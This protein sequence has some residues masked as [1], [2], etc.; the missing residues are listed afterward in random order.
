SSSPA[1]AGSLRRN[2]SSIT[3]SS[4]AFI[5]ARYLRSSPS[6]RASWISSIRWCASR[7][8]HAIAA[9]HGELGNRLR[10]VTLTQARWPDEQRVLARL[11]E[12]Q[13]CK[14]EHAAFRKP[15]VIAPVEVLQVLAIWKAGVCEAPVE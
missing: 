6:W 14:L 5:C 15:R 4:A 3:S 7:V 11:D 2:R 1:V 10:T 12:L 8:E 13:R 9:L